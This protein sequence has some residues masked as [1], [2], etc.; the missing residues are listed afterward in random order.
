MV[1]NVRANRKTNLS[2]YLRQTF[3]VFIAFN[4]LVGY[5]RNK[6]HTINKKLKISLKLKFAFLRS[7]QSGI[8]RIKMNIRWSF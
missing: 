5:P 2:L 1:T 8:L 4:V 3:K 7:A 6:F